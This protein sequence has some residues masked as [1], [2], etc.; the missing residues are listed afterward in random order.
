MDES[1]FHKVA[2]ALLDVKWIFAKTMPEIPHWYTLR[3]EW[4]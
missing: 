3:R 4:D 1:R 2:K